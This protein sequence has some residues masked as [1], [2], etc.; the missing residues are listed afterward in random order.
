MAITLSIL[1][2]ASEQGPN[3]KSGG[4]LFTGS[5]TAEKKDGEVLSHLG[6][7]RVRL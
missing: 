4:A 1:F 3:V 7:Y 2:G 5:V 6:V